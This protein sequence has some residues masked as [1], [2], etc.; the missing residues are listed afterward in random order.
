M[1]HPIAV[2]KRGRRGSAISLTPALL[3]DSLIF[4]LNTL[5]GQSDSTRNTSNTDSGN[6]WAEQYKVIQLEAYIVTAS[7][8]PPTNGRAGFLYQ[9]GGHLWFESYLRYA[10][11]Q[12]RL[13]ERDR[14]DPRI[15]PQGT[16]SWATFNFR[17]GLEMNER[18]RLSLSL[19]NLFDKAYREHGS[20]INAPGFNAAL[21]IETRF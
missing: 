9:A 16:S 5:D 2:T 18:L 3:I 11:L 20:G 10:F 12:D 19:E 7:R 14:Q 21:T 17:M 6:H 1:V 13:S 15:N 4:S 8:I